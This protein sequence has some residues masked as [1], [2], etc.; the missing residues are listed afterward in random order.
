LVRFGPLA[1]RFAF[2]GPVHPTD[3]SFTG[4]DLTR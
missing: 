2:I 4:E 3:K 1:E